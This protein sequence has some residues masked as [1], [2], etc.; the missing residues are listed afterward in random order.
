MGSREYKIWE[1]SIHIMAIIVR[2]ARIFQNN[3][4]ILVVERQRQ[5]E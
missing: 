2:E 3:E 4:E 5:N 1:C